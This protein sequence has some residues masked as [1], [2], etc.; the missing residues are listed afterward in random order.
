MYVI[1]THEDISDSV[2][3]S[4][5]GD[6]WKRNELHEGWN[7]LK[8]PVNNQSDFF[9]LKD[10]GVKCIFG[11]TCAFGVDE[12]G[13]IVPCPDHLM[14]T[15]RHLNFYHQLYRDGKGKIPP[16]ILKKSDLNKI[17]KNDLS[18]LLSIEGADSID[19]DLIAL[20]TFFNLGVRCIGLTWSYNNRLAGGCNED[21]HLTDLGVRSIRRM[22][23]LGITLDLAH[24]NKASCLEAV[25][26]S[27]KPVIVTHT[28]CKHVHDHLRNM[29]DEELKAV[30]ST[31]GAVGI[32]GVPKMVGKLTIEKMIDHMD[33]M[34][35]IV[36]IDHVIMG[37]DFGSMTAEQLIPH[38]S[39]V[40]DFPN[41]T[42]ALSKRGWKETDIEK[43]YSKNILRILKA[44]LP[45]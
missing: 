22:E 5:H 10:G 23:E 18:I 6:F 20:E 37:S 42:L 28:A 17:E 33:H 4:A 39:E 13:T 36:G 16:F 19:E 34:V 15:L 14:E 3:Y 24:I 7:D 26:V 31:G 1:D 44:N 27:S 40:S 29:T 45:K 21:G 41:L 12:N 8:L 9:R 38:F 11:A 30:A 32:C 25:E 35:K 2:L 43:L